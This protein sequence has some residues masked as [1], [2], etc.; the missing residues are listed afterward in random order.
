MILRD[1]WSI[2]DIHCEKNKNLYLFKQFRVATLWLLFLHS[3][4]QPAKQE[5]A[6]NQPAIYK[7]VNT[8]IQQ[9]IHDSAMPSK[10]MAFVYFSI[11]RSSRSK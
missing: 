7:A 10:T 11:E 6:N 8:S 2:E 4:S 9:R 5:P 1:F 3:A